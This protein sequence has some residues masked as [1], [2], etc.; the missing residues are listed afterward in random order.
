MRLSLIIAIVIA[1]AVPNQGRAAEK[2]DERDIYVLQQRPFLRALRLELSPQFGYT[3]NEPL[4]R[5]LQVASTVRFHINESW[6]VGGTYAHYFSDTSAATEKLQD[7]FA[8]FPEKSLIQWYAGGEG[9][10][11]PIYGKLILF[12]S[13]VVHWDAFL[14]VGA[15]VTKT[16]A[17]DLRFTASVGVG[18]RIFLTSWLTL[19]LE[20]KDYIYQEP[21]KAGDRL[22]NNVVFH[23]GLSIFFPFTW[24]YKL[25]K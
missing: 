5:Y 19:T 18:T 8:L 12:E 17:P 25:Q 10:W 2:K 24:E 23:S 16:W 13:W 22:I 6:S 1:V 4:F 20:L 9:S 7:E 3:V 11:V 15:G 14:T 21:F